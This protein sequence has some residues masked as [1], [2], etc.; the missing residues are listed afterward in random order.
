[1]FEQ[2]P[3]LREFQPKFYSGGAARFHLP[4]FYDLLVEA[5]PKR[6][7]VLGFGDG[8]AFFTLCQAADEKKVDCEVAAVRR[9]R[10][11]ETDDDDAA[12]RKGREYGEEFYGERVRF[13]G[14][15][16]SALEEFAD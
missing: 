13:L 10:L 3:S 9:G 11:A 15:A 16:S 14:A 5:K 7:M 1:M 6:V 12:W 8:E 2:L 4:F